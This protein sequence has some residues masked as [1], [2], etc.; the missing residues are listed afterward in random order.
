MNINSITFIDIET[1][2]VFKDFGNI[3]DNPIFD[4]FVKK[5]SREIREDWQ[6]ENAPETL[7]SAEE[8]WKQKASLYAEF[9]KVVSISMGRMSGGKF[10]IR[11]YTSRHEKTLLENF[12]ASLMKGVDPHKPVPV[13]MCA[14]NGKEFDFPFLFRRYIINSLP[15]PD[16]LEV[17]GKKTWDIPHI[18]TMEIWSHMQWKYKCSLNVL[19]HI[20]GIPSPKTEM[21]GSKVADV[22][23]GSFDVTDNELPFDKEEAALRA[24]GKYNAG[25]VATLVQVYLRMKGQPLIEN[26]K[27]EYV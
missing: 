10:K 19:A 18:D 6:D 16:C 27:I 24:I 5:F 2:P 25:D 22:Y 23:Y 8:V 17:Y 26:D 14:H 3:L 20:L 11:T 7:P 1:V 9:G 12:T 13:I 21:D 4:L 15:I